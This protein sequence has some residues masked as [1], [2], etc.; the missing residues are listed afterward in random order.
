MREAKGRT[1]TVKEALLIHLCLANG[2]YDVKMEYCLPANLKYSFKDNGK[3]VSA[4]FNLVA[5]AI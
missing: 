1:Q 5:E 4:I 3:A 2:I